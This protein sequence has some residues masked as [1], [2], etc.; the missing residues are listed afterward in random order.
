MVERATLLLGS[1]EHYHRLIRARNHRLGDGDQLSLLAEDPQ[2]SRLPFAGIEFG[3][4]PLCGGC[5]AGLDLRER[6]IKL[7]AVAHALLDDGQHSGAR[8]F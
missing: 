8:Q 6:Q 1:F 2:S 7:G 4:R 3:R 5:I